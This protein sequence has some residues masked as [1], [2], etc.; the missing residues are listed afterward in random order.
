MRGN[1]ELNPLEL[2][3]KFMNKLNTKSKLKKFTKKMGLVTFIVGIVQG[4]TAYAFYSKNLYYLALGFTIFSICSVV[5]KLK[6]KINYFPL[7]KLVFYSLIL[8]ILLLNNTKVL[9]F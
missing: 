3:D 2:S 6:G 4:L 1:K 7:I 5:F 8:I 9:F